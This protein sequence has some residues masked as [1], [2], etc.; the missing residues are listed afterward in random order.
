MVY[1][2]ILLA[3]AIAAGALYQFIG[4]ARD[5][6][7]CAPPGT[8]VDVGGHRLHL[9]CVGG[10]TPTVVFESGIAASSL[11][12]SRVLPE[13]ANVTRA[14]AYARAVLAWSGAPQHP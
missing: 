4:A 3:S 1:I 10:G 14:C 12:W 5:A 6:R 7:T 11:S 8:M 9:T 13:V 2:G